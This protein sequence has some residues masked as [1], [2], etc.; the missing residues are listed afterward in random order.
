MV[1]RSPFRRV[2]RAL[3]DDKTSDDN[4]DDTKIQGTTL[5]VHQQ[6]SNEEIMD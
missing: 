5:F 6:G 3:E 1:E 4:S 2:I